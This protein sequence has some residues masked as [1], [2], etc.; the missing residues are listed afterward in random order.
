[1]QVRADTISCLGR[2]PGPR[3]ASRDRDRSRRL[4]ASSLGWARLGKRGPPPG[5]HALGWIRT[6]IEGRGHPRQVCASPQDAR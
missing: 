1:M 6:T 3:T 4:T 5:I 2:G